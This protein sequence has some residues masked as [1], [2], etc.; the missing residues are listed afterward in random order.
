MVRHAQASRVALNV[1]KEN[2][3]L[4]L[5][6]KDNGAGFD[7]SQ[8]SDLGQGLH[9]MHERARRLGGSLSIESN[10][11]LGTRITVEVPLEETV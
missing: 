9:N 7:P 10:P 5:T 4:L 3:L 2:G 8:Q 11:S 1:K 6:V